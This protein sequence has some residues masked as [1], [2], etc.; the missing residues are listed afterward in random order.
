MIITLVLNVL[1]CC[2]KSNQMLRYSKTKN[3]V[4]ICQ[5]MVAYYGLDFSSETSRQNESQKSP[6]CVNK[7]LFWHP[8]TKYVMI[9]KKKTY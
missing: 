7:V 4:Y 8:N 1:M 9:M 2:E 3:K 5:K 6:V